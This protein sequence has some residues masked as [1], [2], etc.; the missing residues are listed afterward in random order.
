VPPEFAPERI[1]VKDVE[2]IRASLDGNGYACIKDVASEKELQTA[3][4][5]L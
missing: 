5:M 1:N 2:P 3:R 4:D